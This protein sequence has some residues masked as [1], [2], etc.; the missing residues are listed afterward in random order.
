LV[1]KYNNFQ[2]STS[3]REYLQLRSK[4]LENGCVEYLSKISNGYGFIDS[5]KWAKIYKVNYAHRLAY[6]LEHGEIPKG[7]QVNHLCNFRACINP[8]HLYL[9]TQSDN[10]KDRA[11]DGKLCGED[12]PASKFTNHDIQFIR[13]Q[14]GY[15]SC[16]DLAGKYGVHYSTIFRIWN[17]KTWGHL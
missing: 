15:M 11:K 5:C 7:L 1:R 12:N 4:T 2:K 9:G 13:K 14:Q 10:M 16:F 17:L 6:V 8:K 3:P